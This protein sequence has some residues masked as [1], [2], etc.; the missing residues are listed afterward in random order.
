MYKIIFY[1]GYNSQIKIHLNRIFYFV[2]MIIKFFSDFSNCGNTGK[3]FCDVWFD[4]QSKFQ[5]TD[6]S[7]KINVE[8]VCDDNDSNYT[9]AI[10][11]NT[12]TPS[13]LLP[14]KNVVGLAFEPAEFLNLNNNFIKYVNEKLINYFIGKTLPSYGPA[15]KAGF[16]YMWFAQEKKNYRDDETLDTL[17]K[18]YKKEETKIAIWCSEKSQ[19]PGHLYRHHL[20]QS[21]LSTNM[22]IDIYG[23]GVRYY[24]ENVN[25]PH[26]NDKRLKGEF[27]ND[28]PYKN[29]KY[30]I[31]IEN[32]ES[33]SYISEKFLSC[34][35]Y[36]TVPIYK[37][38]KNVEKYFG[39][40]CVLRLSGDLNS[41]L[42]LLNDILTNEEKYKKHSIGVLN[43]RRELFNGSM[44]LKN[45]IHKLFQ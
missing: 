33:E 41:D 38:A 16:S 25:Y 29:Y 45:N 28:E 37:G 18:L 9:H 32:F 39:E 11:L 30:C 15:F 23:R 2:I 44:S 27:N 6:G 42:F 21:I 4:K 8:I 24:K 3:T 22:N 14:K 12:A 35:A 5:I 10:I 7:N 43:S 36:N 40:N 31:T 1:K 13:L 26:R 20:V 34:I 19:A 17:D